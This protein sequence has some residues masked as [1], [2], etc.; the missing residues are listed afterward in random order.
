MRAMTRVVSQRRTRVPLD[1]AHTP[2][3]A[4]L[5]LR[6]DAHPFALVGNWAGGGAIV[7]SQP[8]AVAPPGADPFGLLGA[9]REGRW[10]GY[11]GYGLG[12]AVERLPPPPPRPAPLPPFW[13]GLYDHVLRLDADGQ[14]WFEGAGDER[15]ELLARRMA[16]EPPAPRPFA[17]AAFAPRP[18][19]G[20]HRRAVAACREYIAAGDLYQANLCLRLESRLEGAGID[21]FAAASA[22]LAP[23]YAAYF[24]GPWGELASLSPELFLRRRGREVVTRPI[25]G[26]APRTVPAADLAGSTKDVAENVMI[27]DL[28]RNDLGRTCETGSVRVTA[29]AEPEPHPGVWHLVSEV[30][31]ALADG[32]GDGELVRAAFPPGSVTGAPK[33][34]A[35]EVISTLEATAREAYTGT[36]GFAGRE[37]SEFNVAI[38]TFEIRGERIWLGAGGGIVADSDPDAEYEECLAK[39]RPLV[40]AVGSRIEEPPSGVAPLPAAPVRRPRPDPSLGVFETVLVRGGVAHELD[41]HLDRLRRS[42]RELYGAEL[43]PG[44]RAHTRALAQ[45]CAEPTRLRIRWHDG[46]AAVDTSPAA[47]EPAEPATLAPLVLPGGLGAHKWNDRRTLDGLGGEALILD[48]SGEVLEAGAGAVVLAEGD[49]LVSPPADG[50][51]LPSV[52]LATLPGVVR[53]PVTLERLAAADGVFVVSAI[54]RRQRVLILDV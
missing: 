7:G 14:W 43:D 53:E 1:S 15:L 45:R 18:G 3:Q 22:A 6:D 13:L 21:L 26:T 31:G 9:P 38:R 4:L 16:A 51:I 2:Q 20:A 23:P 34:K 19:R 17:C 24:G 40:E 27:V 10:F 47:P 49:R 42:L 46:T 41:D 5:A 54:R 44:L 48:L 50:R 11:L 28:M 32:A 12:A 39:A 29:T 8:A 36:I 37:A 25:K 52:T 33:I 35:M 30:R